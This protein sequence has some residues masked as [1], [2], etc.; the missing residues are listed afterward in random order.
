VEA[1]DTMVKNGKIVVLVANEGETTP[2]YSMVAQRFNTLLEEMGAQSRF[3]LVGHPR[4]TDVFGELIKPAI[5]LDVF[6]PGSIEAVAG[7]STA[8]L[9][10][11]EGDPVVVEEKCGKGKII[12]VSIGNLYSNPSIGEPGAVPT[13][14]N[15]PV[16]RAFYGLVAR[17]LN[18]EMNDSKLNDQQWESLR[19]MSSQQVA[20]PPP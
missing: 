3:S 19:T 10:S 6:V 13:W 12:L 14:H 9:G 18:I 7:S 17:E 15:I 2:F 11:A 20:A 1:I 5:M 8:L 16:L 4:E